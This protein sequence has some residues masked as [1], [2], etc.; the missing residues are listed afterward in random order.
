MAHAKTAEDTSVVLAG[1]TC[2][3]A[4][5]QLA[6]VSGADSLCSRVSTAISLH[7]TLGE[8]ESAMARCSSKHR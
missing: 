7:S 5:V 1:K 4:W 8:G 2:W 3:C 6:D